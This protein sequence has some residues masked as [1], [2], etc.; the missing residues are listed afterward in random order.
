[1]HAVLIEVGDLSTIIVL[2]RGTPTVVAGA[3]TII[4]V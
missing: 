4:I 3:I 2:Y 1:M